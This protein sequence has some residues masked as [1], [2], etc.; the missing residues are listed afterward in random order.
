[1]RVL[2]QMERA[3]IR[4]DR[5]FLDEL[6]AELGEQCDGA[7]AAHPRARRR[8]VQ[9]ELDAAAARRPV[10][11]A[12]SH[13]GEEDEDRARRPTPTRCRRWPTSTRSSRTSSATAR[14]RSCAARTPTRSRR[15][16]RADGRIHATF[17]QTDTTTGRISSEAPNLQNVPVRTADGREIR[18]AFIADDGCGHPH[19]RL[20]ADR[21]AGARPPRRGPGA[22]RRVRPGRR[23]AHRHRGEGVRR[24]R[25]PTVD[26]AQRR[27][28]KVVNYGLAYGMEAYGLGQ[29]L[30]I[31]TERGRARSST[32]LRRLPQRAESTWS[33]TV[34]RGEAAWATPPRSSVAGARSPS[35]RRTTSASARWGSA[36]RRTRR[37]RARRPTSSS[38]R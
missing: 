19:R 35:S 12:R 6:S 33:E 38:S 5:E 16:S 34:Q 28:A 30:D 14:S 11:E 22:D 13:A 23:R 29:R 3:G 20:L 4:I 10:R 18:R 2:A 1:M 9:R 7:G 31:P 25:R 15:S 37:C 21:A 17:K 24:R 27:F 26:A 32:L 8:G 36:W